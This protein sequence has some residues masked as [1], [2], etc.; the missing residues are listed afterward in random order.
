MNILIST[1]GTHGN[2]QPFLALGWGL[3]ARGHTVAICTSA[4]Y[5]PAIEALGL[6][7]AFMGDA[8]LDLTRSL[9]ARSGNTF[10]TRCTAA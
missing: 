6:Q 3:R 10:P 4:S 8:M 2:V 5:R 1:F 7:H 9:L